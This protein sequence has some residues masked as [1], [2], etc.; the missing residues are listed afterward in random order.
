MSTHN[1]IGFVRHCPLTYCFYLSSVLEVIDITQ[2]LH[3][4]FLGAFNPETGPK[5]V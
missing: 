5:Q 4:L 2:V 1:H 3:N